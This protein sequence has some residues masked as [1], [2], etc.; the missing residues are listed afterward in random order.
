MSFVH[1]HLHTEYSL[2]DGFAQIERL[3]DKV[4]ELGMDAVAITDHGV[5]FGAV[6]FYKK[7]KEHGIKPIVGCEVYLAARTMTDKT[8]TYDKRRSHLILLAEN[9]TGYQNLIKLVS[10]GFT[11]GFYYKPRIDKA[12]LRQHSEGLI[13]LSACLAGDIQTALNNDDYAFAK[14]LVEDYLTIF[15]REHFY[16]EL[17]DHGLVEQKKVN[18]MLLKLAS[19]C[20]VQVVATNDVHYIEKSDAKTHDV[21]L[22]IQTG[23]TL[24][25]KE[26]MRFPS[27]EFYLKSPQQMKELFAYAPQAIENTVKIA[28]RCQYDFDF[29]TTHL[30]AFDPPQPLT[31]KQYLIQLCKKGIVEKYQNNKAARERLQYELKTIFDMGYEDYF[32]IVWD[33]VAFAKQNGILVGPCRGS[34]GGSIVAYSLGI[35]DVDPLKYNLIFERFLNPERITMPDFDID[36]QDDRRGEVIDYVVSKYGADRVAQIITFG[37]MGARAAIRDVGRVLGMAYGDVDAIAKAVPFQLGITIERALRRND[38]LREQY[39]SNGEV[40]R[41]IDIAK[42]IEGMPR[43]ASTHAAGVVISKNP[44]DSYVPLYLHDKSVSTQFN[45]DILAELGL[46]KFDFLGL[47]TLTII[48]NVLDLIRQT[49][50]QLVDLATMPMN[51]SKAFKLIAKGNTLGVFQLESAGM[52]RFMKALKPTC[53]EDIIAGVSLYRPGP[54]DSIPTYIKNKN[55]PKNIRYVTPELKP[56]LDVTYGCLVYQEQVMEI[57][58]KLG[59]YSYGQSDLVRRAMSKKKMAVMQQERKNFVYGLD[60]EDGNVVISGC[61]RNGI[62]AEAAEKIFDDMIDFAKYA[63]NKSHATGYAII[64]YQTAYL[65]ANYPLAFMAA[66]MTAS[67]GSHKKIARY[68]KACKDMNIAVLAPDVKASQGAFSV[69]NDAIRFGLFAI[70][71]VGK[72]LIKAIIIERQKRPF[73]D[74]EDFLERIDSHEL[75][76]KAIESL[77]KAG[78]L[79]SFGM[80]RAI[81]IA[82][83]ERLVDSVQQRQRHSAVGQISLFDELGGVEKPQFNYAMRKPLSLTERLNYEKEVIGIY[84]SAHPL[85]DYRRVINHI[86]TLNIADLSDETGMPDASFEN[87]RHKLAGIITRVSVK[88]TKRGNAM[89]F[90]TLEDYTGDIEVVVFSRTYQQYRHFLK[91]DNIVLI[92]GTINLKDEEQVTL[93]ADVIRP[94]NKSFVAR[95]DAAVYQTNSA[96]KTIYLRVDQLSGEQQSWLDNLS[97]QHVG[98]QT[99]KIFQTNNQKVL[100]YKR[101]ISVTESVITKFKGYFGAENVRLVDNK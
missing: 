16:L 75:N 72:G 47:T 36:F 60:D 1:L 84:V 93:I 62:A 25:D 85:D 5:M 44:I 23:K 61:V 95:E 50:G 21:L 34:G 32:L 74:I 35:I 46:L 77:I 54:M 90:V 94:I 29:N 43:H 13:A 68:I 49:T 15:D 42:A 39:R 30:P 99:I 66:C 67:M 33:F 11:E 63:F 51:D 40:R 81:L 22:A 92:T 17:Q 98:K 37:T 58:R 96:T 56:I 88:N 10:K 9:K 64:A 65:K 24:S 6:E 52:I 26:R 3:F 86:S 100:V 19:E 20:N 87:Q 101:G 38:T 18:K 59:G 69:E 12:L 7:A 71:H 89:A 91:D 2:L 27:E 70:K 79:D 78:A 82:N 80:Q 31:S 48:K 57:V 55:N 73:G 14:Q 8:P 4:A 97:R 41:L 45:M 83:Y 53:V 76:K 28:E